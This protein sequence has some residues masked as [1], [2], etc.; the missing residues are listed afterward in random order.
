VRELALARLRVEGD[1]RH[2]GAQCADDPTQVSSTGKAQTATHGA[3]AIRPVRYPAAA[4][5]SRYVTAR[6]PK[7][8]AAL[9]LGSFSAGSRAPVAAVAGP[10]SGKLSVT[11]LFAVGTLSVAATAA[12]GKNNCSNDGTG[13]T[14]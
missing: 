1:D 14:R 2:T 8:I 6:S 3:P 4:A 12:A 10:G 9:S 5:S 11:G 13:T 7:Q